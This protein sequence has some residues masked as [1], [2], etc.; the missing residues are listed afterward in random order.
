MSEDKIMNYAE[1]II[2]FKPSCEQEENDKKLIVGLVKEHGDKLLYR[3]SE[4]FHITSS[5][6]TMNKTL[7][8]VL[9]V[10]NLEEEILKASERNTIQLTDVQEEMQTKKQ[11][12]R[13]LKN[14]LEY[15]VDDVQERFVQND[16]LV[17]N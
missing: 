5:S 9:M 10:H 17:R 12:I 6:L 7:D 15:I 8:K 13:E 14:D 3:E 4:L 2:N 16:L 11:E 1:E